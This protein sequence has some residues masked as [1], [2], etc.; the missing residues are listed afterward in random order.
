[1]IQHM[2]FKI[3]YKDLNL[4]VMGKIK[5][6]FIPPFSIMISQGVMENNNNN[7]DDDDISNDNNKMN[8]S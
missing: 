4:N 5:I 1:M 6:K 7:N 2:A 8:N 3:K